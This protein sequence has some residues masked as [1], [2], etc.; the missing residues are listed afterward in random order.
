MET[1]NPNRSQKPLAPEQ[2]SAEEKE[3][4]KRRRFIWLLVLGLTMLAVIGTIFY[5]VIKSAGGD[6]NASEDETSFFT[7]TPIW[8]AVFLPLFGRK[9]MGTKVTTSQRWL[10]ISVLAL[11]VLLVLGTGLLWYYSAS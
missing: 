5:W 11:T 7:L 2:I 4:Q 10:L 9:K 8:V 6:A 1:T 3:E